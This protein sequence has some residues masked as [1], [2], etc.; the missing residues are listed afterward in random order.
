MGFN[1][2]FVRSTRRALKGRQIGS[3]DMKWRAHTLGV[4]LVEGTETA[5]Q[6]PTL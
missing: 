5:D 4:Q 3:V 6:R 1:P 2:G